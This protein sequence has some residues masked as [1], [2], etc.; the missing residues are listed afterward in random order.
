[1]CFLSS[2][3]NSLEWQAEND[4]SDFWSG[5]CPIHCQGRGEKVAQLSETL[6]ESLS[7]CIQCAQT[8]GEQY[9]DFWLENYCFVL[10]SKIG[11]HMS[12]YMKTWKREKHMKIT[13]S[14]LCC[15]VNHFLCSRRGGA[16]PPRWS[17]HPDEWHAFSMWK[18]KRYRGGWW[19]K[20]QMFWT[21]LK[22]TTQMYH[23]AHVSLCHMS[24]FRHT[25][26]YRQS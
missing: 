24:T 21:F 8:S 20:W 2:L 7:L 23:N 16:D 6:Q 13:T 1:M 4:L 5:G 18:T 11:T 19:K 10:F 17:G 9:L 22:K 12:E 15:L 25:D 3:Q 14:K 26:T